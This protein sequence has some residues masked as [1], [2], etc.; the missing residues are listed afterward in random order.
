MRDRA[1]CQHRHQEPGT[2]EHERERVLL[3]R[4]ISERLVRIAQEMHQSRPEENS[5]RELRPEHQKPLVPLQ[6]VR[7]DTSGEGSDEDEDKAPDL[8]KNQGFRS[9]VWTARGRIFCSGVL[10]GTAVAGDGG[11]EKEEE[12]EVEERSGHGG[13]GQRRR[14]A[15]PEALAFL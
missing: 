15:F 5:A 14:E 11:R 1:I 2:G 9:Q 3:L 7:R 10:I 8:D 12:D 6:K 13:G 4:Q